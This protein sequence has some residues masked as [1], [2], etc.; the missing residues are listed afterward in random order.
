M[1]SKRKSRKSSDKDKDKDFAPLHRIGSF[2]KHMSKSWPA[3]A[4]L[5]VGTISDNNNHEST[6]SIYH[7]TTSLSQIQD[8]TE[9]SYNRSWL[10]KV[11]S[12]FGQWTNNSHPSST[13]TSD[14]EEYPTHFP[15]KKFMK[16]SRISVFSNNLKLDDKLDKL[17]HVSVLRLT[18]SIFHRS[19]NGIT[20]LPSS[21]A[22]LN[23]NLRELDLRGNPLGII[24]E[25]LFQLRIL[26]ILNL[27]NC[28]LTEIPVQ[29]SQLVNLKKLY[30]DNNKITL[31][32]TLALSSIEHLSLS[33]NQIID[34]TG[35]RQLS[36]LEILDVS[37]NF[38]EIVPDVLTQGSSLKKLIL[39]GNSLQRLPSSIG[40]IK[41]LKWLDVSKNILK[42]LPNEIGKLNNLRYL[43]ISW[44]DLT[45]LPE[46]ITK[47][48]NLK[49]EAFYCGENPLQKPPYEVAVKGLEV[50][51]SYF[52]A[53]NGGSTSCH[54]RRLKLMILGN[55]KTGK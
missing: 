48:Q 29:I 49:Q 53:L 24:P 43:N 36:T 16:E 30:L 22:K 47:L 4:D 51:E 13:V 12:K 15:Y 8:S 17:S 31:N 26:T 38:I 21:F 32:N 42:K 19:G 33:N 41:S 54:S 5:G 9:S 1:T 39:R 25:V 46:D 14:Y 23:N 40:E 18:K 28:E 3:V 44:N 20:E 35:I 2:P 7:S 37:E 6:N 45:A 11:F 50:I 52:K 27:E 34:I 55:E 10:G